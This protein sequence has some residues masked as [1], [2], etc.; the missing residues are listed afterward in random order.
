MGF[1][2][3]LNDPQQKDK[4][5][6]IFWKSHIFGKTPAEI[7]DENPLDYSITQT[8][9]DA[10]FSDYMKWKAQLAGAKVK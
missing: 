2:A 4:L 9:F 3:K 8:V 7:L 5:T 6:D 10:G 1:R